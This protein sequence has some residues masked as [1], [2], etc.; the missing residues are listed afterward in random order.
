LNENLNERLRILKL[1]EEGKINAGEAVRL[2]DALNGG[3]SRKRHGP[4]H[5]FS[6][7][8]T[9]ENIP[10][11][12]SSAMQDAFKHVSVAEKTEYGKKSKMILRG[13]SGDIE[14][15][16]ADTDVIV[17]D[18]EGLAKVMENED[19]LEVKTISGDMRITMPRS[20][21][22]ELRGVSGDIQ[23]NG[24]S[25]ILEIA[26][27]DGDINGRDL[28]GSLKVNIVSGDID[29]HYRKADHIEIHEKTGDVVLRLAKDIAAEIEIRTGEDEGDI[30]CEFD[31]RDKIEKDNY[32]KGTINK[33][34]G[35]SQ[36]NNDYGDVSIQK[37]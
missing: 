27:V 23:L 1:L 19:S 8:H 6:F 35:K 16:G 32:L 20:T 3:E 30:E 13:V 25:G 29:L 34:G 22:L 33:G 21:Q 10:D 11:M 2:L 12:V 37:K 4:P 36:I 18:K 15:H 24:L 7:W 5:G 9:M 26:S 31:L 28:S 14:I 17:I